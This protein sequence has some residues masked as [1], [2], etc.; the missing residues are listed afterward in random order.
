MIKMRGSVG[1]T[2]LIGEIFASETVKYFD[3]SERAQ[4]ERWVRA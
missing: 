2:P 3:A 4:A 1:D